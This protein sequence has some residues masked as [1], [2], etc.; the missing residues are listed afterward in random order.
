M[1]GQIRL[2]QVSFDQFLASK[3]R[4]SQFLTSYIGFDQVSSFETFFLRFGA[5][6][7]EQISKRDFIIE[8][9]DTITGSCSLRSFISNFVKRRGNPGGWD[10][11]SGPIVFPQDFPISFVNSFHTLGESMKLRYQFRFRFIIQEKHDIQ[12]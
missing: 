4:L 7:R 1:L 12:I 3:I 11:Q 5:T 10:F 8:R 9:G 6:Q 2:G